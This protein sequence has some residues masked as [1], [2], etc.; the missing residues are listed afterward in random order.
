MNKKIIHRKLTL[1]ETIISHR[2]LIGAEQ[3]VREAFGFELAK[4]VALWVFRKL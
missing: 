1:L 3:N 4:R 2:G